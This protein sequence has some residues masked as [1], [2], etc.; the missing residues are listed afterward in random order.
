[1]WKCLV[2]AGQRVIRLGART[3]FTWRR[4]GLQITPAESALYSLSLDRL[5]TQWTSLGGVRGLRF[6]PNQI[7]DCE[8]HQAN[9]CHCNR[10][11]AGYDSDNADCTR[12]SVRKRSTTRMGVLRRHEKAKGNHRHPH[13]GS[14]QE[15]AP[16]HCRDA[17]G[18]SAHPQRG[19]DPY[20]TKCS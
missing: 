14:Q 3:Y 7:G 19:C 18:S 11:S 10:Q 15:P 4:G 13:S 9:T 20:H 16:T 17:L 2:G 5:C 12:L 1:V 6:A 8:A